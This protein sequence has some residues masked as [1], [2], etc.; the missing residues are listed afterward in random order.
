MLIGILNFE[1]IY[2]FNPNAIFN[3]FCII[4]WKKWATLGNTDELFYF[5]QR[6]PKLEISILPV[7]IK[8]PDNPKELRDAVLI[9]YKI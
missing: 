3:F 6:Y 8:N 9:N 7:K 2:Q 1:D 5:K 4:N